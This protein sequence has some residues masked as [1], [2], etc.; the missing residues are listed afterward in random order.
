[1]DT[2]RVEGVSTRRDAEIAPLLGRHHFSIR[3]PYGDEV[4]L[5]VFHGLIEDFLGVL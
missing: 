1:M 3:L 4:L 2:S 5:E